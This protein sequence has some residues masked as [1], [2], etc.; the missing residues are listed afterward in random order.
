[1][2]LGLAAVGKQFPESEGGDTCLGEHYQAE[3]W[4]L[5]GYNN[6]A[7]FPTKQKILF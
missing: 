1:M 6:E 2:E 7:G 3:D 4:F 5:P